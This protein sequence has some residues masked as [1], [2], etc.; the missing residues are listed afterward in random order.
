ML[1][2]RFLGIFAN[3]P[4][5]TRLMLQE[6]SLTSPRHHWLVENFGRSV[7]LHI[8]PLFD[9]LRERGLLSGAPSEVA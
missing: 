3:Q 6:L 1:L 8:R 9:A 2:P 7:W 4:R 5:M